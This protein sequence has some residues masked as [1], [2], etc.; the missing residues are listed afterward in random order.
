MKQILLV[1]DDGKIR[2]LIRDYLEEKAS[3]SLRLTVAENGEACEKCLK[4]FRYDLLLLD[5]MLPDTDGFEICRRVREK[6]DVPIIFLTARGSLEDVLWGYGLGCDDYMVKPFSLA[7]LLAKIYVILKRG[8]SQT[9]GSSLDKLRSG[10]ITLDKKGCRVYVQGEEVSLQHKQFM[11]LR[12]LMENKGVVFSRDQLL[13]MVWGYD[14]DGVDRV[15]DNQVKLLRKALGSGGKQIKT[16][17][18]QGY[19]LEG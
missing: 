2:E 18:G 1:E 6:S 16:V 12:V 5:V 7:E 14:Y 4:R 17:I 19:K 11:L 10:E 13:D 9:Q 3:D 8:S 15:V